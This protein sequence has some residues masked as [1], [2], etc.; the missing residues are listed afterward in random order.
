MTEVIKR[1]ISVL[2]KVSFFCFQVS[3]GSHQSQ[4]Q[5]SFS[6]CQITRSQKYKYTQSETS[7]K[8]EA[9]VRHSKAFALTLHLKLIVFEAYL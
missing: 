2:Q 8:P 4:T 6:R 1:N 7:L 3:F 9:C 5:V